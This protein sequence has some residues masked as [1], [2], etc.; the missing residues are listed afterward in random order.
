VKY[1]TWEEAKTK[2]E[3]DLDLQEEPDIL[4]DGEM[5]G[6]FNDAIDACEQH[7]ITLGDYFLSV[8]DPITVVS[9]TADYDLP[10]DIYATKIRKVIYN[11][12]YEIKL[13]KDLTQ[14]TY[15][16]DL[17]GDDYRYIIVNNPGERPKLR[18]LPTPNQSGTFEIYYT[19]NAYRLDPEEADSQAIDIPEAMNFIFS[20]VKRSIYE[21]EKS[22]LYQLYD[23]QVEKQE[24]LLLKALAARVDDDNN[25]IE[26]D[27]ELYQDHV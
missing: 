10:E 2:I 5:M 17:T 18:L 22:P 12:E 6:Y 23:Q 26:P 7:F 1:W 4:A 13:L 20:H 24:Q 16:T 11:G 27:I 9:G 19:R 3:N 25:Y 8:T 21:K 14:V 15:F